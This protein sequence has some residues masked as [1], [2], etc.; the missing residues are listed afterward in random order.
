[1]WLGLSPRPAT[2][3]SLQRGTRTSKGARGRGVRLV[4]LDI[5]TTVGTRGAR[6]RRAQEV[7]PAL[8]GRV[9]DDDT[10]L[11]QP[12]VELVFDARFARVSGQHDEVD[13]VEHVRSGRA[14]NEAGTR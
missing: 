9:I 11:P 10:C 12:D 5:A 3:S 4:E 8:L 14:T 6:S 2:G 7:G 1:M 13:V